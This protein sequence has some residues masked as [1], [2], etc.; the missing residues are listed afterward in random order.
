MNRKTNIRTVILLTLILGC[1]H[2]FSQTAEELLPKAIQLEEVKGELEQA[3]EIY[4]SIVDTY[5]D[6]RPIAAEAYYHMGRCYEKLG[7]KDAQ[8]AYN[9]VIHDYADQEEMVQ[10]AKARIA[11]LGKPE[12][13]LLNKGMMVRKV[14]EGPEVDMM[15]EPSP[16]GKYISYVDWDTGDLAIYEISTGKKRRLTNTG[17]WDDPNQYAEESIWSPDGKQIVYDWYIDSNPGGIGFYIIDPDGSEPRKL[18]SSIELDWA[19]CY[20][21]SADGKQILSCFKKKDKT[22]HIGLVSV[23]DGSVRYLKDLGKGQSWP[24]CM[25]FSPDGR[26]IVFDYAQE[27]D[28]PARDIFLLSSDGGSITS[29]VEH[30]SNDY[31]LG[32]VPDGK[33]VLFASNRNGTVGTFIIQLKDRTPVGEPELINQN[34]GLVEP[35]GFAKDGSYYY[36]LI[37][38]MRDIYV[39]EL[40]SETGLVKSPPEKVIRIFE[41]SNET[42]EYSPDGSYLAYV[43]RR[44]PLIKS[45]QLG[46]GGDLL[47]IKS[48]ESGKERVLRPA[49]EQF[50]FPTWSP[51]GSSIY[52]VHWNANDR[53]KLSG[54]DVQSGE[55]T[56]NL[57]HEDNYTHFGGHLCSPSGKLLYYGLRDREAGSWNIIARELESGKEEIFYRSDDFYTLAISPDGQWLALSYPR[58]NTPHLT[59]VSTVTGESRELFRFKAGTEIGMLPSTCWS[60]DG[61]YLLLGIKDRESDHDDVELCRISIVGAEIEK[62]GIRIESEFVNLNVHPDGQHISFSTSGQPSAEVWVMD[63]FLPPATK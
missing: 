29:L 34:I 9:M 5:P 39:A 44:S 14:W 55:I 24:K 1:A 22:K 3:I 63:N 57:Q 19:I 4:Q 33:G 50:G 38:S 10:E 18:W 60:A 16:D 23:A 12:K 47:I 32:W 52:L 40:D 46:W 25:R 21:W 15:G 45:Y 48:L 37:Q 26:Y 62:L 35:M 17:S 41:G 36:G 2:A 6:N 56:L 20:D 11:A 61:N 13:P 59:L 51:D 54:I 30:P 7:K 43:S 53:I 58:S 27:K 8:K 28:N 42:P 31:V 49:L